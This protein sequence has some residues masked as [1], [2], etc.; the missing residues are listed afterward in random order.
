MRALRRD[1]KSETAA[2]F[3]PEQLLTVEE[4][5]D[6]LRVSRSSV[7]G[8]LDREELPSIKLGKSR[9]IPRRAVAELVETA[10]SGKAS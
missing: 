5:A 6:L 7:Y 8:M 9:R 2:A 1:I 10:L 4:T 3:P